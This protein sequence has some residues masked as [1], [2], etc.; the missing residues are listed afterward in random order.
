M[1]EAR[2]DNFVI[3]L[4]GPIGSGCTEISKT[5][6][7]NGSFKR[8]SL[9]DPIKAEFEE[10]EG[11]KPNINDDGPDWRKKL[12]D[13][14][15]Q[16]RS[17]DKGYWVKKIIN[18]DSFGDGANIVVDGVRNTNEVDELR[19]HFPNFY[20]IA[21]YADFDTRWQRVKDKYNGD[22]K[23]FARDEQRDRDEE[24][25]NGQTVEKCVELA[26]YVIVNPDL[27]GLPEQQRKTRLYEE[28]LKD[29]VELLKTKKGRPPLHG[30]VHMATA[31]SLSHASMCLKRHVGAVI[32]NEDNIPISVGYNENPP[33]ARP[34]RDL[35]Y[36]YKDGIIQAK[37]QKSTPF[38]CSKCGEKVEKLEKSWMCSNRQCGDDLLQ[39]FF[40]SRGM[41]LCTAIHAEERAIRNLGY[42]SAKEATLYV[43][44][45][46][47][48][49]CAR[50]I[51]D[52]GITK[53]VYVEAYPVLLSL[54]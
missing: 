28:K 9:S 5:L 35:K 52:V 26:D 33:K 47:C 3:G 44:T 48:F 16:R 46:P 10:R 2:R 1:S 13:I 20:L 37:L 45:F 19:H 17:K 21:V 27:D 43:N 23:R 51:L 50:Y 7:Q 31:I 8:F 15:N 25:P 29:Q 22:Q 42:R 41:E 30:E 53:V 11:H 40:P 14:G 34:C 12:Q 32:V 54:E 49:Q 39:R 24:N 18:R 4:T 38:F 36:C 6:E